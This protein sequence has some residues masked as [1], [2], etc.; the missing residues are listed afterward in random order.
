MVALKDLPDFYAVGYAKLAM[1]QYFRDVMQQLSSSITW[2]QFQTLCLDIFQPRS[3]QFQLH[4]E[5]DAIR[6]EGND[7]ACYIHHFE[8]PRPGAD[9]RPA[10]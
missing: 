7:L 4:A 2:L 1:P 6:M 5:F 3:L 9:W 10:E 8:T